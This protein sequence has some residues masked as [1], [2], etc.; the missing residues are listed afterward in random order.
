[1]DDEEFSEYVQMLRRWRFSPV[2]DDLFNNENPAYEP[3]R[4]RFD[5]LRN[6]AYGGQLV[7]ASKQVGI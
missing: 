6:K 1:M 5:H 4:A 2:G 7:T 3:W